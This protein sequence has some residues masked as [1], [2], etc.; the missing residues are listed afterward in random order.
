VKV[1][2]LYVFDDAFEASELLD[3]K[4]TLFRKAFRAALR[5]IHLVDR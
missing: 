1:S 3:A 4:A 2:H 5:L